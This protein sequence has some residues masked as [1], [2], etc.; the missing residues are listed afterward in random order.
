[1]IDSTFVIDATQKGSIA[2]YANH[3]CNANC[4]IRKLYVNGLPR[5]VLKASRHIA[6]NE[7]ITFNY[8]LVPFGIAPEDC[9]CGC[10]EP[11][12][13]SESS[14][15]P[16]A[17]QQQMFDVSPNDDTEDIPLDIIHTVELQQPAVMEK[18]RDV[19]ADNRDALNMAGRLKKK[20]GIYAKVRAKVKV[21]SMKRGKGKFSVNP[22]YVLKKWAA[23][24]PSC[25]K[26][27]DV[28][29]GFTTG[30]YERFNVGDHLTKCPKKN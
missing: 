5:M 30:Y 14:A 9:C 26:E 17:A 18:F 6:A 23:F 29:K 15:E 25:S 27:F 22:N 12:C 7:E 16:V 11:R 21:I 4:H 24:C 28:S 19:E 8:G 3:S 2:R 13:R 10:R 1:M 20:F